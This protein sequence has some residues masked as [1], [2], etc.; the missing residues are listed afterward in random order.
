MSPNNKAIT[1]NLI[2]VK[3]PIT[4]SPT[5]NEA[6]ANRPNKASFGNFVYF[7][8]CN[9]KIAKTAEIIKTENAILISKNK[10]MVTP[11]SAEWANVP[12]KKDNLLQTT[13]HP[14]GPVTSE[15][16]IPAISALV[17]KSS[18]II[19]FLDLLIHLLS[20]ND[21]VRVHIKIIY[22]KPCPQITL[23]ISHL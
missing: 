16:P 19:I 11:N 9:N 7:C 18:N 14:S 3:K 5:A 15:I 10:A 1:S 22:L 4:T 20:V 21:R 2:E 8:N 12:A 13:K 6:W 17:K 23:Y